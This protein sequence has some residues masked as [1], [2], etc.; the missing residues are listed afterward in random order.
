MRTGVVVDNYDGQH[1]QRIKVRVYGLHTEQVDG[2]YVILDD[3]LPWAS[4]APNM[5]GSSGNFSVPDVG[6]RVYVDGDNYHLKYYGQVEVKADVRKILHD[7]AEQSDKFKF[8]AYEVDE[9]NPDN[10][11]KI[12]YHPNLGLIVEAFGHVLNLT[13]HDGIKIS[14]KE[15]CSMEMTRDGDIN[16]TAKNNINISCNKLNLTQGSLNEDTVDKILSVSIH[17]RRFRRSFACR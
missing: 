15:G 13:K 9:E 4:P 8:I 12:Y 1:K 2:R 7:N 3:D 11:M 10:Y 6:S 16:L 14:S 17:I 5:G